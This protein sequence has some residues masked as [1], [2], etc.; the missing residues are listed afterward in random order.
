[1]LARRSHKNQDGYG[2]IDLV[3]FAPFFILLLLIGTEAGGAYLERASLRETFRNAL[4]DQGV[5]ADAGSYFDYHDGEYLAKEEQIS[6]LLENI[7]KSFLSNLSS[8]G[9]SK[10][11]ITLSAVVLNTSPETGG[12]ESVDRM[13]SFDSSQANYNFS[14]EELEDIPRESA[15]LYIDRAL[16]DQFEITPSKYAIYA[17][18][19][20]RLGEAKTAY[21]P[22]SLLIYAELTGLHG[23]INPAFVKSTLGRFYWYQEQVLIPVRTLLS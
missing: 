17:G 9:R 21:L 19:F 23:S 8:N 14:D 10:F 16:S 13:I 20:Y 18:S 2:F 5:Y 12:I 15:K 3:L 6:E 1:M 22:K 7:Q 11:R 4:N